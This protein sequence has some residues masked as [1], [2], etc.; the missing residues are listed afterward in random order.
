MLNIDIVKAATDP[1]TYY[2]L[3]NIIDEDLYN[4]LIKDW[5]TDENIAWLFSP[6]DK[7]KG[8]KK[9]LHA[10]KSSTQKP[11]KRSWQ[12]PLHGE[13]SI[14]TFKVKLLLIG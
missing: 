12:K 4:Q 1:Y 13:L 11:L 5:P 6:S 2:D 3:Q 9:T 14:S 10:N 8:L 7:E